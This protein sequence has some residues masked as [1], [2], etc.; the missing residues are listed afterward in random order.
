[1]NLPGADAMLAC[2]LFAVDPAGTGG[3]WLRARP[4]PAR[5]AWLARL[6]ALLAGDRLVRKLPLNVADDRLL[7]GLDLA[8]TLHTGRPVAQPGILAEADGG[9]LLLAMAERMT[10]LT[11]ARLTGVL[12]RGDIGS[13]PARLGMI[14]LDEGME[15]E[16]PPAA[17][18]DRLAFHLDLAEVAGFDEPPPDAGRIA[19]ARDRLGQVVAD[20]VI[21]AALCS[22]AMA[23]G[24]ASIRAP[25][26]AMRVA[27]AACALDGRVS[28]TMEDAA[29][30]GRL[31]FARRATQA[32]AGEPIAEQEPQQA[33]ADPSEPDSSEDVSEET[34]EGVEIPLADILLAAV[35]AAIPAGLLSQISLGLEKPRARS[36][37]RVG[38]PLPSTRQGR[39]VGSRRGKSGSGARL[40]VIET[41]K[42]AAPWQKLRGAVPGFRL[43]IRRDDFRIKVFKQR[44]GTTT[45][46]VVDAS[47]SAALA[48]LAETKGAVELLLA[49]CHVRRDEVALIAFRGQ[50]AELL[51]PPTHSLVR[52]KRCLAGL[53]GG[54][55]TPIAHGIDAAMALAQTITFGGRTV[56]LTLLTDGRANVARDGS[57]G[58]ARAEADALSA[59]GRVRHAKIA[60]MLIDT[61]PRPNPAAARLAGEM[62]AR[63]VALPYA[64]ADAL[65]RAVRAAAPQ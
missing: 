3:V 15:D 47:G 1:M 48:R 45:V 10:P 44:A 7:G 65:S 24:I 39:P 40:H 64:D 32:P 38:K 16:R 30:A 59:A 34:A 54:G 36:A 57:P 11:A 49:D 18:L 61:S 33:P 5:D 42:A 25:V 60:A 26:L 29:I 63:Y 28:T 46:F 6:R 56:I 52:A 27:R 50:G 17:L 19:A 35:Q 62:G 31:V 37:G 13:A 55:G 22:T 8:A 20:D 12:D 9:V 14:A 4:D 51:L 41:L 21:L 58:R 53:P 23:L 2:E 43:E